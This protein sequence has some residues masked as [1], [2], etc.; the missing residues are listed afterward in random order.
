MFKGKCKSESAAEQQSKNKYWGRRPSRI[1]MGDEAGAPWRQ[2]SA[3][4][5]VLACGHLV[6]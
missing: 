3:G 6:T 2:N 5:G 4:G 1:N